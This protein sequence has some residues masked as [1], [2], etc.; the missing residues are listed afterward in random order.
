[1][2]H[3]EHMIQRLMVHFQQQRLLGKPSAI[4]PK[5]SV[6]LLFFFFTAQHLFVKLILKVV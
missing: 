6:E 1:M 3:E 4:I 2:L 5:A